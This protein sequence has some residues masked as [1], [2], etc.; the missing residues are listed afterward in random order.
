MSLVTTDQSTELLLSC[1]MSRSQIML[2]SHHSYRV[3]RSPLNAIGQLMRARPVIGQR[4]RQSRGFLPPPVTFIHHL[5]LGAAAPFSTVAHLCN[6][7]FNM[8]HNELV[9]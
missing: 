2:A 3:G 5:C 1:E 9:K 4:K 7:S 6:F 8:K